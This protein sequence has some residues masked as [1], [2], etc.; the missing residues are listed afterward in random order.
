M[1]NSCGDKGRIVYCGVVG[2]G[3]NHTSGVL[4]LGDSAPNA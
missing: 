4:D 2:A 1:V 3:P